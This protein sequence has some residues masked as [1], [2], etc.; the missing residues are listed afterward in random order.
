[1]AK[2]M[3]T[4]WLG[5]F[6]EDGT[7]EN[8]LEGLNFHRTGAECQQENHVEQVA[9]ALRRDILPRSTYCEGRG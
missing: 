7:G 6:R 4:S 3:W 1:M 8:G 5:G 9:T 2:I